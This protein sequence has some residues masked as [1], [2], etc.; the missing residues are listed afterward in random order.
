MPLPSCVYFEAVSWDIT[1]ENERFIL[2]EI[3]ASDKNQNITVT[4]ALTQIWLIKKYYLF[5][6]MIE[7]LAINTSG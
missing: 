6:S 5:K 7:N 4:G 3:E 1:H 2:L